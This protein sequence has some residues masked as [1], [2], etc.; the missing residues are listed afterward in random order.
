MFILQ[1]VI[2]AVRETGV[3][4][5]NGSSI[6]GLQYSRSQ[7]DTRI[8]ENSLG[9][10]IPEV[11]CAIYE[12]LRDEFLKTPTTLDWFKVAVAGHD[13]QFLLSILV[14][15]NSKFE[16]LFLIDR[17]LSKEIDSLSQPEEGH[18]ACPQAQPT[19]RVLGTT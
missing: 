1:K 12:C 8:H 15:E 4:R 18:D 14:A 7:Y 11:C 2:F 10:I 3:F 5:H 6:K 19:V 13:R 9:L 16:R 17:L